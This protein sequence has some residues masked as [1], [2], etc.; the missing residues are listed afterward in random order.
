VQRGVAVILKSKNPERL[1]ANITLTELTPEEV[2]A[3]D[4]IHK[5]E[6]MHRSLLSYHQPDGSVFGWMYEQLGWP[7]SVGGTVTEGEL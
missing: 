1:K 4:S 3:V 6:G 5:L 2:A 7:M